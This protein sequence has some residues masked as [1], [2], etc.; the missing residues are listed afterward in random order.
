MPP[1]TGQDANPGAA[2]TLHQQTPKPHLWIQL[3]TVSVPQK[4]KELCEKHEEKHLDDQQIDHFIFTNHLRI[5]K[6]LMFK[7]SLLHE[8]DITPWVSIKK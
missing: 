7:A 8:A 2:T 5:I 4:R 1:V 3:P 6:F